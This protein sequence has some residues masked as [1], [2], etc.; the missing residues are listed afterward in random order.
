M[1][2]AEPA[3][4]EAKGGSFGF[5]VPNTIGGTAQPNAWSND[6]V[7]FYREQRIGHQVRPLVPN[8]TQLWRGCEERREL[9]Q[10]NKSCLG[11]SPCGGLV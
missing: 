5:D 9:T 10:K 3:A 1:H 11:L 8:S 4:K 7:A 2:L 6:W